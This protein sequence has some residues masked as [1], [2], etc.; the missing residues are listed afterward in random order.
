M[1]VTA[2]EEIADLLGSCLPELD[3]VEAA[4]IEECCLREPKMPLAVFSRQWHLSTKA[5]KELRTRALLTLRDVM[6]QKGITSI[7]D[8]M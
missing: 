4:F 2:E 3:Q 1:Q 5:V 7:A 8:I 6:A